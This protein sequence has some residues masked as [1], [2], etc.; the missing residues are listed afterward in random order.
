[1]KIVS[2]LPSATD[3]VCR[4]G[5]EEK[6]VGRSHSCDFPPSVKQ[7]P[8]LTSTRVNPHLPSSEIHQS[9]ENILKEAVT[10]Y[11]LDE[12]KLKELAPDF[13]ITQNLCDVCAVSYGQV[14]NACKQAFGEQVQLISLQPATLEGVWETVREVA[15]ALGAMPAC[16]TFL[17]EVAA[18]TEA[19]QQKVSGLEKRRVLTIEWIDPVY[20]GGL[21]MADMVDV[22]GGTALFSKSGEKALTLTKE[23]L[24]SIDPEAVV[25]KP[26]GFKLDQLINEIGLL[27]EQ[28]P[29]ENWTAAKER[30]FFFVDGNRYFNRPGPF[31]L[32]SLEILAWCTHPE[33]FTEFESRYSEDCIRLTPELKLPV[34]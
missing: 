16:E 30:R 23:Q 29:W 12:E 1:M 18:R 15:R 13:I 32:E 6:L 22:C 26:C 33:A 10:V 24:G 17:N 9:V 28:V 14:E 25:V 4:L 34:S 31:L 2:L 27:K 20:A 11:Q 21:W 19:I 5:L 8:A 7:L 3:I